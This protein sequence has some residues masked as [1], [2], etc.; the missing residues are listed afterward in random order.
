MKWID[1][2]KYYDSEIDEKTAYILWNETA[3]P[4]SDLRMTTYQIRSAI[5]SRLNKI[6]R[7]GMCGMKIPFHKHGC[8][9]NKNP[10]LLS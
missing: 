8:L 2:M 9:E 10:E 1:F 4:F 7:C 6:K 3:F 5:R